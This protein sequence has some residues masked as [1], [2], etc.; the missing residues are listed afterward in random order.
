M[1]NEVLQSCTLFACRFRKSSLEITAMSPSLAR[2]LGDG[3]AEEWVGDYV[4]NL[5]T[6][7]HMERVEALLRGDLSSDS[8]IRCNLADEKGIC[9]SVVLAVDRGRSSEGFLT[10]VCVPVEDLGPTKE[11]LR[12]DAEAAMTSL[13]NL[14]ALTRLLVHDLKGAVQIIMTSVGLLHISNPGQEL[15][16]GLGHIEHAAQKMAL[17]LTDLSKLM[18]LDIGDYPPELTDLN[19]LVDSLLGVFM[20]ISTKPVSIRRTSDLPD[21]VCEKA[22]V[23][24]VFHN[25]F[26]NATTYTLCERPEVE[27]GAQLLE[28]ETIYFVRDNGVG[29]AESELED[30]FRPLMRADHQ[31]L[32]ENGTGLGLPQVKRIIERHSG[33]IWLE[34][35]IGVG[36]TVWFTLGPVGGV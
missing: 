18:R 15:T 26:E 6:P 28:G 27:I 14:M 13:D 1:T 3:P 29:I 12:A 11:R 25:L 34:S 23:R 4:I 30:V 7:D 32:N 10:L 35:T 24:E 33:R 20:D 21:F 17:M 31:N 19:F 16:G 8:E 9:Q 5:F 22:L 2:A 36:T